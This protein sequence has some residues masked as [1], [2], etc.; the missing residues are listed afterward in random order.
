PLDNHRNSK[1]H[2]QLGKQ[3]E[4][5]VA[6]LETRSTAV[7]AVAA[8]HIDRHL[9]LEPLRVGNVRLE[10]LPQHVQ[11][12]LQWMVFRDWSLVGPHVVGIR[13]RSRTTL[14]TSTVRVCGSYS[15]GT[16]DRLKVVY[17]PEYP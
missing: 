10:H 11:V 6:Y 9:S 15:Q 5:F 13:L 2:F 7:T 1:R 16:R 8:K 3:G 17:L 12:F 14:L 4:C